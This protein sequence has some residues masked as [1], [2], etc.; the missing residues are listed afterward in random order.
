MYEPVI[1]Q[2]G[3]REQEVMALRKLCRQWTQTKSF[4]SFDDVLQF[5][6]K[7]DSRVFYA[8]SP[9]DSTVWDGVIMLKVGLD[10]V[11][12]IYLY[13]TVEQRRKG[14]AEQLL[15]HAAQYLRDTQLKLPMLLEVRPSNV[16]AVQLYEKIGMEK[17]NLRQSYYGDGESAQIYRWNF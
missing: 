15:R 3:A 9:E 4:W 6:S 2:F 16:A 12:L 10:A 5:N 11:D 14:L 8:P 7:R 1:I 13:V 17:L